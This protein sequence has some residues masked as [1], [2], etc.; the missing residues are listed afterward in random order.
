[1]RSPPP[2]SPA[3]PRTPRWTR[4]TRAPS[5][6]TCRDSPDRGTRAITRSSRRSPACTPVSSDGGRPTPR[7]SS[8]RRWPAGRPSAC[9][10]RSCAPARAAGCPS[11]APGA[12]SSSW[13]ARSRCRT[14]SSS[15]TAAARRAAGTTTS[16]TA[17]SPTFPPITGTRSRPRRARRCSSTRRSTCPQP[18]ALP[19]PSDPTRRLP[20]SWSDTPT[21]CPTSRPRA[22]CSA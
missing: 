15:P 7:G 18:A 1:M 21:T 11:P 12:S 16:P 17:T 13:M 19:R 8:P 20:G 6:T 4:A 9:T 3:R 2:R 10:R 14:T 5:S 22:R